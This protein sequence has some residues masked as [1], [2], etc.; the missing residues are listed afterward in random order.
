MEETISGSFCRDQKLSRN[1]NEPHKAPKEILKVI[2]EWR[3]LP[4]RDL[5][6][7]TGS[8]KSVV[9]KLVE[10]E[11]VK[12]SEEILER[13]PSAGEEILPSKPLPLNDQQSVALDE[14]SKAV[15]EEISKVFL[16]YGV[17]GS[18]K[19]EV[20]LQAIQTTL[21]RGRGAI[22][23]VPEISFPKDYFSAQPC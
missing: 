6:K 20:Y 1:R 5:I 12:L 22:V 15:R 3:V 16:L 21:A 7:I 11:I 18:G 2:E 14:I 23:L 17:T 4:L 19:T 9:N 13:D 10:Y 8:T